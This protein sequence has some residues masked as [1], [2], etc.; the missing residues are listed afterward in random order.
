MSYEDEWVWWLDDACYRVARGVSLLA[1]PSEVSRD[2]WDAIEKARADLEQTHGVCIFRGPFLTDDLGEAAEVNVA[3]YPWV[4]DLYETTTIGEA[5]HALLGLL[6]G[7]SAEAI[8]TFL[9]AR[10]DEAEVHDASR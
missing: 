9:A 7:Y 2:G 10:R 8:E 5:G 4:R 6:Y 1:T 3:R